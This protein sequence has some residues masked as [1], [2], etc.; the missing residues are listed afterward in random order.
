MRNAFPGVCYVCGEHVPT[1]FG[2][3][4][5]IPKSKRQG[6]KWR[7]KCVK[8]TDG[9]TVRCSHREV[10]NAEKRRDKITSSSSSSSDFERWSEAMEK[11]Y[12]E[13]VKKGYC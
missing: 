13:D 3:F 12:N 11:A 10:K 5:R 7:V 9:R 1:G 8:C 2:F 4:E 6:R